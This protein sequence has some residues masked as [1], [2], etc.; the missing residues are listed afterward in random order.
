[1]GRVFSAL[2]RLCRSERLLLRPF[3]QNLPPAEAE[4]AFAPIRK[5]LLDNS[6]AVIFIAGNKLYPGET[7]P[8]IAEGV[9]REYEM[10][11]AAKRV[12]IPISCTGHAAAQ[13]WNELKPKLAECFADA[14]VADDFA[15]LEDATQTDE[16]L[17]DAVFAI[18][19]KATRP[20][21]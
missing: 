12:L 15:V 5:D 6:G 3:P 18:L 4:V 19:A 16:A 17:L 21:H 1:M 11:K 20:I 10:A 8:R 14:S 2:T 13:I 9:L 7:T